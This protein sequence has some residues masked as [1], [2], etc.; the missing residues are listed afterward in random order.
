MS[1]VKESE[2]V[3]TSR[4]RRDYWDAPRV[5]VL[6]H[7][8]RCG[9]VTVQTGLGYGVTFQS[10]YTAVVALLQP[11]VACYVIK[12]ATSYDVFG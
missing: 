3:H 10:D 9:G 11:M 4:E 2:Q 8:R 5:L 7:A 1:S 12:C 6:P